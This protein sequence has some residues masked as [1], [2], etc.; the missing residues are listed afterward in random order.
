MKKQELVKLLKKEF[1]NKE[2]NIDISGLDFGDFKGG[3]ILN[4]IKSKGYIE[5]S[6]HSNKG[7]IYQCR[8]SNKGSIDQSDHSNKGNIEQ[9]EHSNEGRIF[10]YG[11]SNKSEVM[12]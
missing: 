7:Y 9:S 4:G 5:Q 10:Q 12:N 2:G 1:T 3:I 11:H 6:L 8:H